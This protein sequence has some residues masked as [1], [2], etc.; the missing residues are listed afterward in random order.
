MY[1]DDTKMPWGKHKGKPLG[2]LP[3]RY[4]WWMLTGAN[5]YYIEPGLWEYF[6]E[7]AAEIKEKYEKQRLD[8]EHKQHI[9]N[10]RK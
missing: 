8:R 4:R 3:A 10:A 5:K 2:K 9:Q 7:R 1:T 6:Y